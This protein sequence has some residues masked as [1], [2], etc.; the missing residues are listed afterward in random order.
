M[1]NKFQ[2]EATTEE[3]KQFGITAEEFEIITKRLGRKPNS[4]EASI[5]SVSIKDQKSFAIAD[6]LF[7]TLT[8][9]KKDNGNI[10]LA[11]ETPVTLD[12]GSHRIG[13]VNE[14][15]I[16]VQMSSLHFGNIENDHTKNALKNA[17]EDLSD[18]SNTYNRPTVEGNLFFDESFN[19]SRI[20]NTFSVGRLD[21]KKEDS[22]N[23][24][25][26]YS[27]GHSSG[28]TLKVIAQMLNAKVN[29][30]RIEQNIENIRYFY[31]EELIAE[32]PI[33]ALIKDLGGKT[34]EKEAFEPD[35]FH[36]SKQLSLNDIKEPDDL[37]EVATFLLK[38]PN[39]ASRRW[40]N[41]QFNSLKRVGGKVLKTPSDA[42]IVDLK[43]SNRALALTITG[44]SR[45]IKANP[46]VGTAHAITEAS[47]NIICSG[48]EPTAIVTCINIDNL[49]SPTAL[50]QIKKAVKGIK[51]A[52]KAF[53]TPL[54]K[55][56]AS[57]IYNS[58][59]EENEDSTIILPAIG[60]VGLLED[61]NKAISIDFKSKGDL[62]FIIGEAVE[63]IASSEYLYSYHGVKESPAPYLN[64]KKENEMQQVIKSL[65]KKDLV[66][67][68]HG[69]SKGGVFVTLAEMAMP[70]EL[71]FDIVTDAEIREDAF[72]FGEAAG[73]VLVGVSEDSEDDFIDFML[74][75]G[76]NFTL[77]GHVTQGKLVVDDDH[78]GFIQAAKTNY[79]T[80]LEKMINS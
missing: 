60:M 56:D 18:Y 24:V 52:G 34:I 72:L 64:M 69:C 30:V 74:N 9:D 12:I 23:K 41:S 16:I 79:N 70:N 31:K 66:N 50:W 78:Y 26:Q 28:K 40:V 53:K 38:H 17:I 29:E 77:L 25:T 76:V 73:R 59:N 39:I 14:M 1:A 46:E 11:K 21:P 61:K 58:N 8:T 55:I 36:E 44:H 32:I 3:I 54:A 22:K 6:K 27:I 63:C 37:K 57:F 13:S 15:E 51:E 7:K 5:F 2:R 33:D 49:D 43:D 42:E 65:I 45:Y 67:A 71:G 68:A 35:Y 47:R 48:G 62:I 19:E 4:I 20:E 10:A 75:T 80:A